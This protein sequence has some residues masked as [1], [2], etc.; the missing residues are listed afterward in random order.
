MI[1]LRFTFA[2]GVLLGTVAIAQGPP[3]P[4]HGG[5]DFF[6]MHAHMG[7]QKVVKGAPYSAVSVTQFTQTLAD[8]SHIQRSNTSSIA[9]DSEGRSRREEFIGTIGALAGSTASSKAVFIHDPVA[10]SSYMLDPASKTAH[11]SQPRNFTL[12]SAASGASE[13]RAR[14]THSRSEAQVKKEELGTQT[15]EGLTVQ[16]M[17]ITRTIAAGQI[18][19]EHQLQIVTE[20]WYSHD[21]QTTVMSTTNDPRTGVSTY[22]LTNVSRAEPD[23]ALFQ[24]PADYKLTQGGGRSHARQ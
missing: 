10:G 7:E 16:G 20:R 3:P 12:D 2:L 9:R 5:G 13:P 4:P 17:R 8:G 11:V 22:K 23:A 14:E 21:L 19:N 6:Y 15:M 1:Q 18:G 24:V